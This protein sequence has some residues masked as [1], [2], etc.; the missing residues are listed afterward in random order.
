[1]GSIPIQSDVID[2]HAVAVATIIAP[3]T[4][5]TAITTTIIPMIMSHGWESDA[6]LYHRAH[7]HQRRIPCIRRSEASRAR[8][9]SQIPSG[10]ESGQMKFFSGPSSGETYDVTAEIIEHGKREIASI[11]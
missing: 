4:I 2:V 6:G 1:V 11:E 8:T 3:V 5:T 9:S 7:G 10:Y